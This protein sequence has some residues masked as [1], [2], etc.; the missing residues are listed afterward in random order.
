M[1]VKP[2]RVLIID[3]V[4][5]APDAGTYGN[6]EVSRIY[7][8]TLDRILAVG[9]EW[10]NADL[11]VVLDGG[12][13][14]SLPEHK[15]ELNGLLYRLGLVNR[16]R[17]DELSTVPDFDDRDYE[18]GPLYYVLGTLAP[19]Y[20]PHCSVKNDD[21]TYTW[22]GSES[23]E[24][25]DPLLA[26]E[27]FF[28]AAAR[29]V[30]ELFLSGHGTGQ[31]EVWIFLSASYQGGRNPLLESLLGLSFND[32]GSPPD[33]AASDDPALASL[34]EELQLCPG[35]SLPEGM[36]SADGPLGKA[37]GSG[38]DWR[39]VLTKGGDQCGFE[40]K[41]RR[42]RTV[43]LDTSRA[44]NYR[45]YNGAMCLERLGVPSRAALAKAARRDSDA[46]ENAKRSVEA[47]LGGA[48]NP[49][50]GESE[51]MLKMYPAILDAALYPDLNVLVYGETGSGKE[52]LY[53]LLQALQEQDRK[54]VI[55]D[56]AALRDANTIS[57]A[58]FG[59]AKGAFTGA[60]CER[61]GAV[62]EAGGGTLVLD[63][64]QNAPP[65]FF[66][67]LLRVLED[68]REYQRL[69]EDKVRRSSCRIIAGFNIKPEVLVGQG[70]L[71][72]DW[73]ARFKI[74]IGIPPLRERIEDVPLLI[75]GFVSN[76]LK[77]DGS[78][79]SGLTPQ[80]LSPPADVVC[81]WKRRRWE[82]KDGNVRGLKSA[83]ESH[84][85]KV[86]V[87][88]YAETLKAPAVETGKSKPGRPRGSRDISDT[89]LAALLQQ[90]Y[91]SP[92][93][94]TISRLFNQIDVRSGGKK[95]TRTRGALLK[96][97]ER[98]YKHSPFE[99]AGQQREKISALVRSL[100][101]FDG[102]E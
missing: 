9:E 51:A 79:L 87:R 35:S 5:E 60:D 23:G 77:K 24:T 12:D 75:D 20:G 16:A 99:D 74:H 61:A 56:L 69:G 90:V 18:L 34:V 32:R 14:F 47:M 37:F 80:Q 98:L 85:R 6:W 88:R 30:S 1:D 97:I 66:S 42:L 10:R 55:K 86:A 3:G 93:G 46:C 70:K 29:A 92:S 8:G 58:V 50:V 94:W 2:K 38:A 57:S 53:D 54:F 13:A 26:Q 52:T 89:D 43:W 11:V 25:D 41:A 33:S 27:R 21:G 71:P 73:P 17:L 49:M 31:Q 96:R 72:D 91:D 64:L 76:M 4:Y 44:S 65:E 68:K 81:E 7:R 100:K 78:Q 15:P 39:R 67:S 95:M 48:A 102:L 82:G 28:D 101:G 63:N 59:H 36:P 83:V 84:V 62:E 19:D 22:K 45:G 40:V